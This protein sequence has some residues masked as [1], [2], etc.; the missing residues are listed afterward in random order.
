VGGQAEAR[1]P[2]AA[3]SGQ[4]GTTAV[5]ITYTL[6]Q[7]QP[8]A[9]AK[10]DEP[11]G[12]RPKELPV[13]LLKVAPGGCQQPLLGG[14][15]ELSA[16]ALV[17]EVL[18]RSPSLAEMVAAWQ[19]ASARYPQVTALDD[20]MFGVQLAPGAFFARSVND[21]YRFEVSQ[22]IPW[23]GKLEL[24]GENAQ[25][26]ASAAGHEVE[27]MRLQLVESARRAFYDYYLVDRALAVNRE[28]LRLL[29]EFRKNAESRAETGKAPLQD[30]YQA[31]VEIGRARERQVSL[32]RLRPV[33]VARINTLMHLPPD[34]PL[35]P[36]PG[37][38]E[39]APALPEVAG[40]LNRALEVRP[41]LRAV[42]D[43]IAAERASLG[44]AHK[45][46]YPDVEVMAA[47]DSIWQEKPLRPQVGVRINLPVRLERRYAAVAEAEARVGQRL[48]ELGRLSDQASFQV[49]QA[50]EQVRESEQVV[51]LYEKT[52]LPAAQQNVKAAQ[53]AY[54]TGS[55]PFLSLLEAQRNVVGLRDR[56]YEALAD[57]FRRRATLERVVGGPL[58][59]APGTPS[60]APPR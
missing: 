59:A 60:P 49:Y 33:A 19:A 32:E 14:L 57:Y 27:E 16:L 52:I 48:A 3:L 17:A 21:G 37:K 29:R 8:F 7:R 53:P 30:V 28:N 40:L 50:Y 11:E 4:E 9:A 38:M 46:F 12:Q 6:P 54:V 45:E 22:R 47:Y 1:P 5:T 20:P 36:P 41:D 23:C 15:K 39:E 25:A 34:S 24:R 56:Y 51:R 35:P 43:R 18:A 42:R 58:I 13:P 44:L 31:D 2:E 10:P 26:Q 55:I